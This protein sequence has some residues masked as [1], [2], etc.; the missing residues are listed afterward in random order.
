M[1]L[2]DIYCTECGAV[3]MD[4]WCDSVHIQAF[5]VMCGSCGDFRLHERVC[6]GGIKSRWR[7][8]DFPCAKQN[9]EFYAGQTSSRVGVYEYDDSGNEVRTADLAGDAIEDRPRFADPSIAAERRDRASHAARAAAG[10]TPI[11][12]DQKGI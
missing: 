2:R 3:T 11:V 12:V 9:P 4:H 10:K 8:V 6:N 7:Y 5:S 1:I